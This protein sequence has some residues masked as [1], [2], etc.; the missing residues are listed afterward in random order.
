VLSILGA[1]MPLT[2]PVAATASKEKLPLTGIVAVLSGL[3]VLGA[4]AALAQGTLAFLRPFAEFLHAGFAI[5]E[6]TDLP[7]RTFEPGTEFGFI[8]ATCLGL[9]CLSAVISFFVNVNFFSLHALYRNRLVKTFLGASN[10]EATREAEGRNSFDGFSEKDNLTMAQLCGKMRVGKVNLYPVLNISLNLLATQK[11][12]WQERKAEPFVCTPYFTGGD[13]VGYRPSA[14]YSAGWWGRL[15]APE[16]GIS[17]GT[18]M[19]ISGAAVSP[20]WGYH[21]SPITSFLMMLANVRLGAWLGNPKHR[22]AWRYNG[23]HLSWRLFMQEALGRTDDEEPW[24]YLSDGG[25]FENLGLY[26][27]VRRRCRTIVVSDAGADPKCTL[28]DLGNAVRKIAIDFGVRIV[29]AV[30]TCA[31]AAT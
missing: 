22:V 29:S 14:L 6:I 24:V 30:F 13:R 16:R 2:R 10:V 8:T 27:M 23:P 17:L 7:D 28:E 15:N 25:H 19:A 5:P 9:L 4:S 12:A 26:E 1:L 11:L 18:A 31:S 20:N 21:S 3:F